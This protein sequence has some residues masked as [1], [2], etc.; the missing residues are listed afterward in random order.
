MRSRPLL[1]GLRVI[2]A[3]SFIAGPVATT[4][5][6]D[7]GADVVKVEPPGGD[8]TRGMDLELAPGV[9]GPFLAVN[10]N[11]RG[12]VLDLKQPEGVAILERLAATADVL[13]E[14]YRPG[15]AKRI[16]VDYARLSQINPRLVYC[17]VTAFGARGPLRDRPGYDAMMQAYGGLMSINGHA[18]QEPA[19]MGTSVVDMG[20]G[21]WAA[22]GIVA[23]LRQRDATGRAVEVS[24]ALFD[25]TLM[26]ASYHAMGYLASGVV[27]EPQGSGTAMIAPYQAFP[28]ADGWLLIAAPS[29]AMFARLAQ[30]LGAPALAAEKGDA[31]RGQA[32]YVEYCSQCHGGRGEGWGWGEK[33]PPPPVPIPDLSN[34]EHMRQLSDQYLFEIIKGGGEAVGRTRFM[35]AAQRVMS[36]EAIW[37]VIAYLR[38]L[39]RGV[40]APGKQER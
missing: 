27:P 13:V 5:L 35:P 16:G 32:L 36:D 28:A 21:M 29:D 26:W 12:L 7:L 6:A 15:V 1:D 37:D 40:E 14:N 2:D 20:T 8:A 9:S 18:G 34:A 19:R 11:K 38:S 22:L 31:A 24:T 33:I 39:S 3:A 4:I 30:A 25:T 23:A 17:A 10:R